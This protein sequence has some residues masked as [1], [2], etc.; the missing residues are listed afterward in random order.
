MF[1][2]TSFIMA[3]ERKQPKYSSIDERINK[4]WDSHATEYYLAIK[5]DE[6]LIHAS[7]HLKNIMLKKKPAKQKTTYCVFSFTNKI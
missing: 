3:K 6:D 7:K 5:K 1:I 4:I 2:P